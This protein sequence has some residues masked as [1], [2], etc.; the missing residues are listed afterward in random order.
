MEL[1]VGAF[2][3]SI[4]ALTADVGVDGDLE[5]RGMSAWVF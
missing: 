1:S 3:L 2:V 5:T 4:D